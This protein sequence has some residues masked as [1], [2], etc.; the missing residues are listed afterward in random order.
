MCREAGCGCCAVTVTHSEGGN[1]AETFSINSCTCPL[2]AVDGWQVSTVEGIGSQQDGF[3]PIQERIAEYNGTQCGY[4]TPGFVMS[5]YGLL[6]QNPKPTQQDIEDSFDGHV[7]RCTG[8][9]PILDAMKSFAADNTTPSAKCIDIEDLNK[10]LCPKTGEVCAG[11][12]TKCGGTNN[13]VRPLALDVADSQWFRPTSL[14]DLGKRLVESKGKR[15]RMVFGNTST[16]IFKNEGPFDVYI[17]LHG[18]NELYE[19]KESANKVSFGGSTTLT[20]LKERLRTLQNKPGFE[21]CAKV[22][23]HLKFLASTLVRNAGCIAGNLMIKHAHPEFPSDLFTMTTAIGASVT[24]YDAAKKKSHD[25]PMVEFLRKVDMTNKVILA[26]VFPTLEKNVHYRSFKITPRSQNAHAYV[27][28]ALCVP[29]NSPKGKQRP[30]IVFGGISAQMD[31]AVKTED[32]LTGKS[33][34]KDVIKGAAKVLADELKPASDN[35]LLASAQYRKN[36]AVNLLYKTLLELAKPTDAKIQS[37]ADS[38]ERPLS[39]GLQTFQEKKDEFPLKQPMPKMTAPLQASGEAIYTSDMPT[40]QREL[41][42]AFVLSDVA[43][44]TL[45]SVDTS[46][47]LSMPGVVRY[48]SAADIPEGG[49]NDYMSFPFFPDMI[50]E[51]IFASSKIGYAGQPIGLILAETQSLA[52][53]AA[54]KVKVKYSNIGEAVLTI[55]KSLEKNLVFEKKTKELSKGDTAAA[56]EEAEVVITGEVKGGSQNYFFLENPVALGV[57]SEDGI[58]LY[59]SSQ[60]P[61]HSQRMA[62]RALNKPNNYFNVINARLGGGFGGKALF[63]T[64]LSSAAAVACYV[65]KRPVRICLDLSSSFKMNCKR[66]PILAKYKAGF[67]KD[68]K[69]KAIEA[70]LNVDSGWN[71]T[72]MA[73]EF[74]SHMDQ[75]YF[76]PNW[77]VTT[78]LAKTNKPT[79]QAV[80]SPGNI[81]AA[82]VIES[83]LEHAAKEL[84]MHPVM[85]KE[86]NLYEKG[87]TEIHG[88]KLDHCTIREVWQRLKQTADI[89]ARL[90][91]VEAFNKSN[92]WRKR[93]LTMTTVKYGMNYFPPGHYCNISVFAA[94]G[95]VSVMTSGVEMG[96]GLYTKVAQAV[97][98]NM[99]IPVDRVKVRPNQNNV[100]PNPGFSGG[101]STSEM[102]VAAAL[103]AASQLTERLRPIREKMPDADWKTVLGTAWASSMD[104][105]ARTK[106][107]TTKGQQYF[108]YCAGAVE[109]EVDVLTGEFQVKRVDIMCDFGE[110]LNPTIDIG[111][112]EGAFIMGLGSYLLEDVHYDATTGQLLNDGTWEY[113]PPTTKD[114]PID[115]RIHFLPDSPNPCGIQSSKAVGEPP[116]ALGIGAL[117]AIKSSI[118]N[119]REELTGQ[120]GFIPVDSPYTVEKIQMSTGLS[121]DHLTA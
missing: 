115:W 37:G 69:L 13:V 53:R 118:E 29:I 49:V 87:Q 41:F 84:K 86:L 79:S 31:H 97:A 48:V 93:G 17:D 33:L 101:S 25:Y 61:D 119:L 117:L 98:K 6:H 28:A 38:I 21:Y 83:I 88:V 45:D 9:R 32:F 111:Q 110:S 57:P 78:R 3:H 15:T 52:D 43:S 58:D 16:G 36:L 4:C 22:V 89:D 109:T 34:T 104:L 113:K 30:S 99:N 56:L 75:G 85:F 65:T 55:E 54:S 90:K 71:P 10:N 95:T 77:K 107:D 70:E 66:F 74:S 100:T 14:A 7:C 105:S 44:A 64:L 103:N 11:K 116:A 91:A 35:P 102:C 80:R 20:K 94:D 39:S 59:S 8:Y 82:L 73:G 27:N 2:Y 51:E 24:V 60:F 19:I 112:V 108:T 63:A 50:P 68:G 47:A 12:S 67:N 5:M 42:A 121:V 40:F 26:L 114:I 72:F 18:V 46:E 106:C 120:Q 92:T 76:V 81:P 62:A 23:K 96:Q 1:T